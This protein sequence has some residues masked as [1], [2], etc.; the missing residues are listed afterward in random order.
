MIYG[1][2][3]MSTNPL[4]TQASIIKIGSVLTIQKVNHFSDEWTPLCNTN[5]LTI[6]ASEVQE[7]DTAGLQLLQYLINGVHINHGTVQWLP[8]PSTHLIEQA[9]LSGMVKM[10][11]LNQGEIK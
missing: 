8:K 7:I 5:N 10:L 6:D 9:E 3:K 1:S 2:L 4:D 11:Q